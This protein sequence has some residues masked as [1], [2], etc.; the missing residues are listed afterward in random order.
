MMTA[1]ESY[2][3]GRAQGT[4]GMPLGDPSIWTSH[5]YGAYVRGWREGRAS[6]DQHA[7]GSLYIRKPRWFAYALILLWVAI[8]L[9]L[10]FAYQ[11]L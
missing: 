7:A 4:S 9:A 10:R 2:R 3:Q 6:F 8:I 1:K 11:A 5:H